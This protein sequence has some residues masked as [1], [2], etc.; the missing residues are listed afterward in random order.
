MV[1]GQVKHYSYFIWAV[2]A[3]AL[4]EVFRPKV[5]PSS[6]EVLQALPDLVQRGL[7]ED[8]WASIRVNGEALFFSSLVGLPIGYLSREIWI[9][10]LAKALVKLRFIGSAAFYLP[11]LFI[12]ADAHWL[13]VALLA[14]AQLFHV[15]TSMS[16]VVLSIPSYRYDDASTLRMGK[17]KSMWYVTVRSTVPDVLTSIRANA[18]GGW[19]MIMFVEGIVRSEGGIGVLLLNQERHVEWAALWAL[20]LVVLLVGLAQD[21]IITQIKKASCPYAA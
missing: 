16:D 14:A 7:I 19:A 11:F 15:V 13:K 3:L 12:L 4:W 21:Y 1:V 6:L 17:W 8:L 10:P 20:I 9:A 18:A 2:S 5:F